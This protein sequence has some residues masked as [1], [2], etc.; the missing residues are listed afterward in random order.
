MIA[1]STRLRRIKGGL[2]HADTAAG[3]VQ[4]LKGRYPRHWYVQRIDKFGL[5]DHQ[6][7]W[8]NCYDSLSTVRRRGL[9]E[10]VGKCLEVDRANRVA[11]TAAKIRECRISDSTDPPNGIPWYEWAERKVGCTAADIQAAEREGNLMAAFDEL[12]AEIVYW[13]NPTLADWFVKWNGE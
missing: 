9:A 7:S 6:C 4:I 8:G 5:P 2:Y 11:A 10:Y 3:L 12:E 1:K 13:D